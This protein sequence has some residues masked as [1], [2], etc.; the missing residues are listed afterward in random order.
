MYSYDEMTDNDEE[1][2]K[3]APGF[4]VQTLIIHLAWTNNLEYSI[5]EL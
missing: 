5:A 2:I 4:Y 1:H 3:K